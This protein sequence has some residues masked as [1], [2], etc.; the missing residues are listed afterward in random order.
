VKTIVTTGGPRRRKKPKATE[1]EAPKPQSPL[2]FDEEIS[3]ETLRRA[4]MTLDFTEGHLGRT[5]QK[6]HDAEQAGDARAVAYYEQVAAGARAQ[7]DRRR[8]KVEFLRQALG[9][10][11]NGDAG[12]MA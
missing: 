3:V 1:T 9:G 6:L 7:I 12:A 5:Q 10:A 11:I 2:R 8:H 4:E